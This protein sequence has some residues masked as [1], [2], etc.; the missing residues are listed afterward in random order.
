MCGLL[1]EERYLS[2]GVTVSSYPLR[3]R[4]ASI[5][6]NCRDDELSRRR[7]N[8]QDDTTNGVESASH[9][10]GTRRKGKLTFFR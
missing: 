4:Q 3:T 1:E 5:I 7:R 8:I 9:L 10:H 2:S 6:K